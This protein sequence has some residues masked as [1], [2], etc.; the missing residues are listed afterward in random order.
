MW[1]IT[2]PT[3]ITQ[4]IVTDFECLA[5][6]VVVA[7]TSGSASTSV[8]CIGSRWA[9]RWAVEDYFA[10]NGVSRFWSTTTAITVFSMHGLSMIWSRLTSIGHN[11]RSLSSWHIDPCCVQI[12]LSSS[13]FSLFVHRHL[14]E[15]LHRFS[16]NICRTRGYFRR[17]IRCL[18]STEFSWSSPVTCTST[19]EYSTTI[20]QQSSTIRTPTFIRLWS[21][22]K[23]QVEHSTTISG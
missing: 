22:Y 10:V 18:S 8:Q 9:R 21:S 17:S 4:R 6:K 1:V 13:T 5:V 19:S 15:W 3:T 14:L 2:K 12:N 16:V 20:R 11:N 7:I 23:A